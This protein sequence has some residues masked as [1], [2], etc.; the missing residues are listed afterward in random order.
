MAIGQVMDF[1][2]RSP[3][4]N[5]LNKQSLRPQA[6]SIF[7]GFIEISLMRDRRLSAHNG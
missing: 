3:N 2:A 5:R 4:C 1:D 6:N 7:T